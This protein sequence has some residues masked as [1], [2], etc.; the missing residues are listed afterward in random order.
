[1]F[2]LFFR[3][4]EERGKAS[5][6]CGFDGELLAVFEGDEFFEEDEGC[7]CAWVRAAR[8][9]GCAVWWE[10]FVFDL[11]KCFRRLIIAAIHIE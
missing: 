8:G 2:P 1:M 5:A 4:G 11:N 10:R 6:G 9:N 3:G 7:V